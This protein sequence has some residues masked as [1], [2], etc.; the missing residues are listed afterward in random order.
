MVYKKV[1]IAI[2]S[3]L[4]VIS[5][6]LSVTIFFVHD[7]II[8]SDTIEKEIE[9]AYSETLIHDFKSGYSVI[10]NL[11]VIRNFSD[12]NENNCNIV[13]IFNNNN[14]DNNYNI[15][16]LE[17]SI[18]PKSGVMLN[19]IYSER[20]TTP[21]NVYEISNQTYTVKAESDYLY[22]NITASDY[23]SDGIEFTLKYDICGKGI[24]SINRF[25]N[26]GTSMVV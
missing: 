4:V 19:S 16:N 2:I 1:T 5:L 14:I 26:L 24:R 3:V 23:Y 8:S 6:L 21:T 13:V 7:E 18:T 22:L 15:T 11:S 12:D 9:N 17:L 20:T 10:T 25:E